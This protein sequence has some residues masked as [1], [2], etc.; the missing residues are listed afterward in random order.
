MVGFSLNSISELIQY[1][2]LRKLFKLG[3]T[4][5]YLVIYTMYNKIYE[6]EEERTPNDQR[7]DVF[8]ENSD[9]YKAAMDNRANQMNPN[10]SVYHSSRRK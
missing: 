4:Y 2:N 6:D 10:N 5:I 7:S 8:N 1:H 3:Y 9:E